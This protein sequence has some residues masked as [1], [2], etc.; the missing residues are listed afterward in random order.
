MSE[1][2]ITNQIANLVPD[3][4]KIL[5]ASDT[6]VISAIL[7][8]STQIEN[9]SNTMNIQFKNLDKKTSLIQDFMLKHAESNANVV[10]GGA[11]KSS[12]KKPKKSGSKIKASSKNKVKK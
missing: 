2:S 12:S 5:S 10:S 11:K 7:L 4:K 6:V 9:M 1:K 3:N 8:L